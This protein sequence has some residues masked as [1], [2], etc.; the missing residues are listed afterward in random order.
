MIQ[1]AMIEGMVASL[2]KR[3]ESEPDD[4][5]GW[6]RLIRSYVVLGRAEDAADAARIALA[7]LRTDADRERIEALMAD[8]GVAP[9][10]A[11]LP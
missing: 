11:A 1:L 8:L 3:L 10:G 5:D 9:A 4:V 7:G 6:L 2:A